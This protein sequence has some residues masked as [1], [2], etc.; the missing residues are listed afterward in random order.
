MRG[1]LSFALL[2]GAPPRRQ[3]AIA[4]ALTVMLSLRAT[5]GAE[6]GDPFR[7]GRCPAVLRALALRLMIERGF[8][9]QACRHWPR[10]PIGRPAGL[11]LS[12]RWVA[13]K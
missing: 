11:P 8:H 13:V 7:R 4:A 2:A 10:A 6:V 12:P 1:F 5:I 9:D 3:S